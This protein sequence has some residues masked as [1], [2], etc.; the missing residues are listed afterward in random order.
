MGQIVPFTSIKKRKKR[1]SHLGRILVLW[2]ISRTNIATKSCDI[3]YERANYSAYVGASCRL[4]KVNLKKI[5]IEN[6]IF[7][8]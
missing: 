8:A 2:N 7:G 6:Q 5:Y 3:S 1:Y 4:L